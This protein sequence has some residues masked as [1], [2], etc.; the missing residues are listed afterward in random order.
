MAPVNGAVFGRVS[1]DGEWL[2]T[3]GMENSK[4]MML[5]TTG[6]VSVPLL[7]Y[8]QASRL[9]WSPDG[10]RADMSIQCG[11]ASGFGVGRTYVLPRSEGTV[12]PRIPPGGFKTEAEIA[13][14]PGV[15]THPYGD[16]ALGPPGVYAFSRI[17]TTRNLY[18]VPLP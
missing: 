1:P 6:R 16:L 17:T 8:S 2:S 11:A 14:L 5:S 3:I 4:M 7:P 12:L 13:A 9:R 18:R 15:E 10:K